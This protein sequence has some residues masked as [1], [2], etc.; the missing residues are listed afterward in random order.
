M[1]ALATVLIWLTRS[2][3]ADSVF[4]CLT[5]FMFGP[6]YPTGLMIVTQTI[7]DDL[8]VGVMGLMGSFG[9]VGS[10]FWPL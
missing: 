10:A 3:V 9:G 1:A 6:L 8:R 4:F 2:I 5:G 7:E